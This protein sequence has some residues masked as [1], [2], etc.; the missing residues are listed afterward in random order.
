MSSPSGQIGAAV[1][2]PRDQIDYGPQGTFKLDLSNPPTIEGL[3]RKLKGRE[4]YDMWCN[5]VRIVLKPLHYFQLLDS[6]IPRPSID[7]AEDFKIWL[8]HS[9]WTVYWIK[10]QLSDDM[11]NQ[12]E[13]SSGASEYADELWDE[14]RRLCV[15]SGSRRSE[16]LL[17]NAIH[18]DRNKFDSL[19]AYIK[20][21]QQAVE[22]CSTIHCP[23]TPWMATLILLDGIRNELPVFYDLT[24]HSL[25]DDMATTMEWS[26]FKKIADEAVLSANQIINTS[27][28]APAA[29]GR[30]GKNSP[31]NAPPVENTSS[32]FTYPPRKPENGMRDYTL[33]EKW[34]NLPEDKKM[35]DKVCAYCKIRGHKT[36]NCF[37]LA[38]HICPDDWLPVE[39]M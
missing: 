30:K 33:A 12:V 38:P 23:I 25:K 10:Q 5:R 28:A 15:G 26:H 20:G 8:K 4:N 39:G 14:L 24:H 13:M 6:S 2:P 35:V 21:F 32:S 37:Y 27:S 18:C 19:A 29:K 7:D 34:R 9:E 1:V 22:V 36:T 16:S 11:L 31:T 3:E 17:L